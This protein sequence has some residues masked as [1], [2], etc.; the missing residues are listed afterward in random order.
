[1]SDGGPPPGTT[2]LSGWGGTAPSAADLVTAASAERVVEAVRA[3]GGRGLLARGLGRSYGDAAQN[4]GGTVLD[5]TA[6]ADRLALD[7]TAGTV[8][9]DAGASLDS[10]MRALLP[11]G[12]FVPVT[13]G[14]RHV[15]V[16]GAVAADVHGKN[17]PTD[18]S[19]GR[20]GRALD[21]VT[22][23]GE[24]RRLQ[25]G[26]PLLDATLGGLGLTGVV[27]SATLGVHRVETSWMSVDTTRANDLDELMATLEEADRL[28]RYSVAWIDCLA[29]GRHLGRG[30]VT[31]GDHAPVAAVPRHSRSDPLAFAPRSLLRVPPVVPPGLLRRSTVAAFNEA[32]FRRA[33]RR[34]CGEPQRLA[35]FFH[36]LDGVDHWNRVYGAAGF[37]QWQ[38]AVPFEAAEVVRRAVT[39]F[40]DA[41]APAFLAVLK[42]FGPRGTG[43][44]SFPVPGWTLALDL[45]AGLAGLDVLLDRLDDEVADASGRVY[46]AKDSRLLPEHVPTMYPRLAEWQAVRREADPAGVFRSDLARRLQL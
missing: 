25:P 44:L 26:D 32:W 21:L 24:M 2:L 1:V 43:H 11:R 33:P 23:D 46:L 12:W 28:S 20:H 36:P 27:T 3:A 7:E 8:T 31:S 40:A 22:A 18:C 14:T 30:V 10:V 42:R 17:H 35:R 39:C 13:P 41:A 9:C 29:R 37:V 15:T 4:G 19:I 34:R 6:L 5:L 16:G 38:V 45:P